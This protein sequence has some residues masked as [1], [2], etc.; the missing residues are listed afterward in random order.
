MCLLLAE[1]LL[2]S[3]EGM[4]NSRRVYHNFVAH[5]NDHELNFPNNDGENLSWANFINNVLKISRGCDVKTVFFKENTEEFSGEKRIFLPPEFL[6]RRTAGRNSFF[7]YMIQESALLRTNIN[8]M[9]VFGKGSEYTGL[10]IDAR[11]RTAGIEKIYHYESESLTVFTLKLGRENIS[12]VYSDDIKIMIGRAAGRSL[13]KYLLFGMHD[14]IAP[15][16]MKR[17]LPEEV[18]SNKFSGPTLNEIYNLAGVY[19]NPLNYYWLAGRDVIFKMQQFNL[20]TLGKR[21]DRLLG[22]PIIPLSADAGVSPNTA[23]LG[24]FSNLFIYNF[25]KFILVRSKI[26]NRHGIETYVEFS[27]NMNFTA[28]AMSPVTVISI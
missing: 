1:M 16:I 26:D 11:N 22:V 25:P 15:G 14:C 18:F 9:P 19:E 3:G 17:A 28:K 24:D 2:S 21:F 5:Q 10:R 13:D 4:Y 27:I 6:S 12:D 23:L 20:D 8:V 7:D